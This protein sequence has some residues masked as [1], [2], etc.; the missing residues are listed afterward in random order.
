MISNQRR[1]LFVILWVGALIFHY[2]AR[3]RW[4][5]GFVVMPVAI[6]ALL[7]PSSIP[8]LL[9]LAGVQVLDTFL[10]LP[11]K[12]NHWLLTTIVD[13]TLLSSY[14]LYRKS[15]NYDWWKVFC[16]AT[17]VLMIVLYSFAVLHKLNSD[18]FNPEYSSASLFYE[19][20]AKRFTFLPQS[21]FIKEAFIPLTLFVE[22]LLPCLL[23]FSRTRFFGVVMALLFHFVIAYNPMSHFWD[24]SSLVYP[25]LLLSAP[26]QISCAIVAMLTRSKKYLFVIGA[27]LSL[28]HYFD[29]ILA[30]LIA[31]SVYGAAIITAVLKKVRKGVH[32]AESHAGSPLSLWL[33][34][35]L[36]FNGLSPYLGL[37][38]ESSFSMFSNLRTEGNT[39]NHLFIPTN[40]QI[41]DFQKDLVQIVSSDDPYLLRFKEEKLQLPF[42]ELQEY[43]QKHSAVHVKYLRAGACYT[44]KELLATSPPHALLRKFL[45]FKPI[46]QQ[47]LPV[48][49][50]R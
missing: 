36:V 50:S 2:H 42:F 27:M 5:E 19:A 43:V 28:L 24:F 10:N 30:A 9:L 47:L 6:W 39:T 3:D 38:T 16:S 20:Y 8:R 11:I 41:F 40:L 14:V 12:N 46:P 34:L 44:D 13:I 26:E 17:C 18:F 37:K 35:I 31:W 45:I 22:T 15:S 23:L 25:L 32:R 33:A 21:D 4:D 1:V 48:K 29:S 7:N 49:G